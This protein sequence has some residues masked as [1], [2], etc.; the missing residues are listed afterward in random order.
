VTPDEVA[1]LLLRVN[2][3]E[4]RPDP[5]NWFTWASGKRA[6]IYCDNRVLCSYPEERAQIADAL[7]EAIRARF[8]DVE[9]I[10]GTATA[11]IPHAAWVAERLGLPMVYVRSSA[12]GHGQGRRVEGRPLAGERV[13]VVEDL[14]SYGGSALDSV[15]AL[16]AEGGKVL[17]VQA[18]FS[19]G[20]PQATAAFEQR[21]LP[22]QALGDYPS[23]LDVLTLD[24][25]QARVLREWRGE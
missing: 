1:R 15:D 11:G 5:K 21:G 6:P 16:Q 3:V 20:L 10:A 25:A 18:I 22:C 2:A 9:V 4:V 23:L 12:K 24:E 8:P 7:V 14:V 17:G 13:V 19:Y